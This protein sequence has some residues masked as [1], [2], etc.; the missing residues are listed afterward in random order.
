VV[1]DL[2]VKVDKVVVV[3]QV[4][5]HLQAQDVELLIKVVAQEVMHL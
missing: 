5:N 1:V 3:V 2:V 4:V